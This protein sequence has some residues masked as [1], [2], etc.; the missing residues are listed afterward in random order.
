MNN[1]TLQIVGRTV[2][3]VGVCGA[4]AVACKVTKSGMPLLGLIFLPSIYGGPAEVVTEVVENQ[5]G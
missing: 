5:E 1:S 3:A 4:V 2:A